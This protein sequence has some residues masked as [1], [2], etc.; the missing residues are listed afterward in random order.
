MGWWKWLAVGAAVLVVAAGTW[1]AWQ[2]RSDDA[3][4]GTA[5]QVVDDEDLEYSSVEGKY[6]FSGTIMLGRAVEQ[7]AQTG[8]GYDYEQPFSGL[9]TLGID[10]FDAGIADLECPVTTQDI[11]YR[12]Q[13]DNLIFNC[14]PEWLPTLGQY[15]PILNL[16]SNHAF[17]LGEA[18]FEEGVQHIEDAGLQS[19]GHGSP[20]D[21]D[22]CYVTAMPVRLQANEGG[23]EQASLPMA[24]CAYQYF[25]HEPEQSEL[26]V[27]AEY[28][29]VMPVIG[30]MLAG[31]DYQPIAADG[32]ERIAR[33]MIDLGAEFVVGNGTHWVQNTEVYNDRLIAYSTGNFIFDQLGYEERIGLSIGA[34]MTVPYDSNVAGW[35]ELGEACKTRND[36]CLQTARERGLQPFA[37]EF[38]FDAIGSY[39][40]YQRV[41]ERANDEQQRDIEERANWAQ[42]LRELGQE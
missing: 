27:I 20:R 24:L 38:T 21:R 14:R 28:A 34:D 32:Q 5:E 25:T 37:P 10:E 42:T 19:V 22:N 36:D 12:Q 29:E 3:P 8:D 1:F 35:V 39:G 18:A 4:A 16:A 30:L 15:Y 6:I 41:T 40:G 9:H 23:E 26:D 13:V 2:Q 7:A 17:D 31:P 11:P 33:Q